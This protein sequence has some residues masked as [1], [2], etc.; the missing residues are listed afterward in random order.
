[1]KMRKVMCALLT[2]LARRDAVY[3]ESE[4]SPSS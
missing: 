2:P 3:F 4:L 1:M